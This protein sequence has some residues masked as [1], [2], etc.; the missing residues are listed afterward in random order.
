MQEWGDPIGVQDA[1]FD[2]VRSVAM[3]EQM[4]D[5]DPRGNP[6]ESSVGGRKPACKVQEWG[7]PIEVQ[8]AIPKNVLGKRCAQRAKLM[9]GSVAVG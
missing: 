7:D 1:A 2:N 9:F 3:H 5:T 4:Q 6:G 8:D